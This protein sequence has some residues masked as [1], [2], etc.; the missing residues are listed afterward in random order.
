VIGTLCGIWSILEGRGKKKSLLPVLKTRMDNANE[1]GCKAP[2]G[3]EDEEAGQESE[4]QYE[5]LRAANI[6][7][8]YEIMRALGLDL[9]DF[10]LHKEH[11]SSAGDPKSKGAKSSAPRKRS[12]S[13]DRTDEGVNSSPATRR[14]SARISGVT[15]ASLEDPDNVFSGSPSKM[16]RLQAQ[17]VGTDEQHEE[18]ERDHLRWAGRQSKATIVG[19]ASYKHTLHRVRICS[20]AHTHAHECMFYFPHLLAF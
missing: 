2:C 16:E 3:K 19:T 17:T 4:G 1:Q 13:D 11:Q 20:S 6:K 9:S 18:L 14:K 7:R 5:A 8:N 10:R 12:S 15:F